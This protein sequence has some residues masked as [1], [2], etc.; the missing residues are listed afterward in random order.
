MGC[1]VVLLWGTVDNLSDLLISLSGIIL[2]KCQ[3]PQLTYNYMWTSLN[4]VVLQH[5]LTEAM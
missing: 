3:Q 5:D 4:A 2:K 1:V